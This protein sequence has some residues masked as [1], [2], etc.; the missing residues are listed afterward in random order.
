MKYELSENI[1]KLR[2]QKHLTQTELGKRIGVT[3]ST[4][5]S[6]ESQDRLPS[7]AVLIRLA[8]EFNV[9]IEYL[10]GVNKNVTI[11]VSELSN[12]QISALNVIVEQ[13]REDNKK[14]SNYST[15]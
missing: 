1:K 6:Y 3:T 2:I 4:V 12:K 10:L 11:D 5:A 7:I 13:F 8:A 9:S 15:W 14:G